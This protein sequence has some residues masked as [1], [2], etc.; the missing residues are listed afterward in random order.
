MLQSFGRRRL[1]S[2]QRLFNDGTPLKNFL[3]SRLVSFRGVLPW[4]RLIQEPLK[5][6]G[7][8]GDMEDPAINL[9]MLAVLP[10]RS[11]ELSHACMFV[12]RK[13]LRKGM[14]REALEFLKTE[15][16]AN[17]RD[18]V[19]SVINIVLSCCFVTEATARDKTNR[20][21]EPELSPLVLAHQISDVEL[22]CRLVLPYLEVW[23]A[24]TCVKLLKWIHYHLPSSFR[25][26]G[27][28]EPTAS[29]LTRL[30]ADNR[31]C[32]ASR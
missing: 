13:L 32:G 23:P 27:S 15:P 17:N 6:E 10:G 19:Q 14:Q 20:G 18:S 25:L 7:S 4:D 12:L 11:L 22:A 29:P 28:C 26:C 9:R 8:V 30:P 3:T 16:I 24:V 31:N 1:T 5:E 2:Y 21:K